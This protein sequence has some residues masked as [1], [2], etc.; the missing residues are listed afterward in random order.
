MSGKNPGFMFLK[1]LAVTSCDCTEGNLRR[2]GNFDRETGNVGN[3]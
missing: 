1:R 2:R 3:E